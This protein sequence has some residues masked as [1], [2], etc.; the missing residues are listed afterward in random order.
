[1][2][3]RIPGKI[4]IIGA[5]GAVASQLTKTLLS[6]PNPPPLR[7][8][9]RRKTDAVFPACVQDIFNVEV[10]QADLTDPSTYPAL[11]NPG[12][13]GVNITKLFLYA[14]PT[15]PP[16][17]KELIAYAKNAGVQYI[18]FLSSYGVRFVPD[19]YIAH[20]HGI[21]EDAIKN[22]GIK[23]TFLRPGTFASNAVN[24]FIPMVKA[25]PGYGEYAA[26]GQGK[27]VLPLP[28]PGMLCAPVAEKD[29]ADVAAVALSTDRLV[30]Q[31]V[32]LCGTRV[33]SIEQQVEVINRVR[34]EEGKVEIEVLGVGEDE[35]VAKVAGVLPEPVAR[36]FMNWWRKCDGVVEMDPSIP[37][38]SRLVRQHAGAS[39][40]L[41]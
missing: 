1:M 2:A 11:F 9:T 23:H 34:R 39:V 26:N 38:R 24:F 27:L 6:L 28:F 35:W 12:A 3:S 10:V 19:G 37:S 25:Q 21:H 16:S 7:L 30:D 18:T 15:P 4:L 36:E 31:V 40:L 13:D 5:T 14:P 22:A 20:H 8:S 32:E 33:L 41:Y 29:I 17:V